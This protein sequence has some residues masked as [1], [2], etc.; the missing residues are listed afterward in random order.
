MFYVKLIYAEGHFRELHSKIVEF[1]PKDVYVEPCDEDGNHL[2][3]E[4]DLP[5]TEKISLKG[6]VDI[7][8]KWKRV[9]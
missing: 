6:I 8:M 4:H 1:D 2:R 7:K 3:R 9:I 5:I